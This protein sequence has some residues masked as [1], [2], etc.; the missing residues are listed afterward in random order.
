M[1][2]RKARTFTSRRRGLLPGWSRRFP[3]SAVPADPS[4]DDDE[5]GVNVVDRADEEDA[6]VDRGGVGAKHE[7]RNTKPGAANGKGWN[8][9]VKDRLRW[10]KEKAAKAEEMR[11]LR[12]KWAEED[13]AR[14]AFYEKR[15]E[16][17]GKVPQEERER[18][19][20]DEAP[21]GQDSRTASGGRRVGV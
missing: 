7:T 18:A 16:R 15:N 5:F 14:R 1:G 10:E 9:T 20:G 17:R 13:A 4:D 8:K 19:T 2:S 3:D 21:R 11:D 12:A 6:G